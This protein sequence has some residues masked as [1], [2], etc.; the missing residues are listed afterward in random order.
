[1]LSIDPAVAWTVRI[2]AA[3][4][5]AV[6]GISKLMALEAFAGVVRNYRLLPAMVTRPFAYLVPP[7]EL[8]LAATLVLLPAASSAPLAA[9]LLLAVFA[10]AMA[11][12]LWRG[13]TDIDCG[14]FAGLLRQK[15][16]WALVARN[17]VL[18]AALLV[19]AVA[20]HGARAL[21]WLDAV[22]VTAGAGTLLLA[23]TV[24]GQLFGQAPRALVETG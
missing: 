1:L 17:L 24:V 10:A 16:S 19:I 13:R 5:H 23:W 3:A 6:A 15:L 20:P 4:L 11:I 7:I 22:T 8:G 14:C 2:V 9:S 12:N 21:G 18:V